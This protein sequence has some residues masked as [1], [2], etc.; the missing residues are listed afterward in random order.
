MNHRISGLFAIGLLL[1]ASAPAMAAATPEACSIAVGITTRT[2]TFRTWTNALETMKFAEKGPTVCQ[3]DAILNLSD[4]ALETMTEAKAA[5]LLKC[6]AEFKLELLFY[7][8]SKKDPSRELTRNVAIFKNGKLI[9][10]KDFPPNP[11]SIGS[12]KILKTL[13]TC[14]ELQKLATPTAPTGN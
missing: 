7:S 1:L 2:G 4:D 11:S 14:A 12:L 3:D 9:Y 13:P 5:A 8:H 10:S 6:N